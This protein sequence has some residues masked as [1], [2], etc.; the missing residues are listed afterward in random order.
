LSN[1]SPEDTD[2][3]S[4]LDGLGRILAEKGYLL[5]DSVLYSCKVNKFHLFGIELDDP[6]KERKRELVAQ[7][8]ARYRLNKKSQRY[9]DASTVYVDAGNIDVV[10]DK[11][12][13]NRRRRHEYTP[14][15]EAFWAFAVEQY[16]KVG[17]APGNKREAFTSF[18]GSDPSHENIERWTD[19]LGAQARAKA[20]QGARALSFKHVARWLKYECWADVIQLP[21]R[22]T[23]SARLGGFDQVDYTTG[24]EHF[25]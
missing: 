12:K 3:I 6:E 15:F 4:G 22:D 2:V 23:A 14:E 7:R 9:V 19:A 20:K 16:G 10:N 1:C 17:S 11:P 21:T 25:S 18:Q 5:F 13:V 24:L 8:Q